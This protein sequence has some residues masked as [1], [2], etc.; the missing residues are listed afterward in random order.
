MAEFL[1]VYGWDSV[2]ISD[3]ADA[4]ARAYIAQNYGEEFVATQ[5]VTQKGGAKIQDAHEAIRPSNITLDPESIKESLSK[6]QYNLYKLIWT[7]FL[8]SQMAPAIY[9]CMQVSI[10][11]GEYGLKA[12]GS[13]L[14]FEGYQK[15]YSPNLDEDNDK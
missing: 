10:E 8:A 3:E 12:S 9:D 5:T 7:R 13:K 14:I 6:D 4:D 11:N 1:N 2:R 15:V